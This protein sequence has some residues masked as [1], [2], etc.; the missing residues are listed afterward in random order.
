[1]K[2]KD[3]L[4]TNDNVASNTRLRN[5]CRSLRDIFILAQC[6]AWGQDECR[7]I[8]RAIM[9]E[10]LRRL[11]VGGE[12]NINV[13]ELLATVAEQFPSELPA[14]PPAAIE[15]AKPEGSP[16]PRG[17]PRVIHQEHLSTAE[18]ML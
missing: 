15:P 17:P 12:I 5:H 16:R 2:G 11:K 9:A 18:V 8:R 14:L 10:G 7:R 3:N 4:M 1:M 6:E 13:A